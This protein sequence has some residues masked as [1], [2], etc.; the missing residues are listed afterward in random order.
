MS[1]KCA[2]PPCLT[3]SR[4]LS[5]DHDEQASIGTSRQQHFDFGG[6]AI[7]PRPG[8][9]R[10]E[11]RLVLIELDV[12]DRRN[13]GQEFDPIALEPSQHL[14]HGMLALV[15]VLVLIAEPRLPT[16]GIETLAAQPVIE[17]GHAVAEQLDQAPPPKRG[18]ASEPVVET[19]DDIAAGLELGEDR[20]E[21]AFRIGRMVKHAVGNDDVHAGVGEGRPE[22]VHLE[23]I[24]IDD[25]EAVAKVLGKLERIHAQVGTYRAPTPIHAEEIRELAGAAARLEHQRIGWNLL[26]QNAGKDTEPCFLT[27]GFAAVHIVVI[28]KRRLLVEILD[29]VRHVQLAVPPIVGHEKLRNSVR[30]RI[31]LRAAMTDQRPFGFS[32]PAIATRAAQYLDHW[33]KRVIRR[34]NS[35][36]WKRRDVH[37]DSIRCEGVLVVDTQRGKLLVLAKYTVS[38]GEHVE[39]R[40]HE[41]SEGIFRRANDRFAAHVETGVHQH[42]AASSIAKLAQEA[43]ETGIGLRMHRLN[44]RRVVDMGHGRDTRARHVELLD[45][46]QFLLLVG[47]S[48]PMLLSNVGHQQHVGARLVQLE[49]L[50][51]ILVEHRGR[52]GPERLA[53][54]DLEVEPL[55]HVRR[56][57]I[58]QDGTGAER[59]WAEFHPSLKPADRLLVDKCIDGRVE[60]A[61]IVQDLV[62]RTGGAQAAFDLRLAKFRTEKAAGHT[63]ETVVRSTRL[64]EIKMIGGKCR[65]HRPA[66]IAGRRL[67]PQAVDLARTQYLSICDAI[68]RYSARQ[69]QRARTKADDGVL[70]EPVD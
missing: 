50:G 63:V 8:P 54:L 47:H 18:Q 52:E 3:R 68:Q 40:P 11:Y 60:Q 31:T 56:A 44:P 7:Q 58:A 10:R 65:S 25:A 33:N 29:D 26:V 35:C 21:A 51:H 48:Y 36:R 5:P 45:S 30:D 53:K 55:L 2:Y 67:D 14:V 6:E 17:R 34:A 39:L 38:D 1:R 27:K 22:Q 23:E 64:I 43:M 69:T 12:A 16:A 24:G 19:D 70:D 57:R 20:P 9:V 49:P 66:G 62:P 61:F 46:E 42:R 59:S 4:E 13:A 28:G 37:A 32:H 41:A 15:R